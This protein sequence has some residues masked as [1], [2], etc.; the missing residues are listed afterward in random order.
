VRAE[1][2]RDASNHPFFLTD[3]FDILKKEQNAATIG[4]VWWFGSYH[5]SG[6]SGIILP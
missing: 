6:N 3:T 2:R 1:C 4:V 5:A